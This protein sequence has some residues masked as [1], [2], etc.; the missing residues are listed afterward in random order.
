MMNL[1]VAVCNDEDHKI[2]VN[3]TESL[4]RERRGFSALTSSRA[5]RASRVSPSRETNKSNRHWADTPL[6]RPVLVLVLDER[7]P[8]KPNTHM[9]TNGDEIIQNVRIRGRLWSYCEFQQWGHAGKQ[10][11]GEGFAVEDVE[12]AAA[13]LDALP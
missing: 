6:D 3:V 2:C 13:E 11:Q 7:D 5:S 10:L 12:L 9:L 8:D 1:Y 4:P